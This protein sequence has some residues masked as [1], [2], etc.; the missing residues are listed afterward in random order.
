[1]ARESIARFIDAA[2]TNMALA[3]KVAAL[4]AEHGYNFVAEELLE[5]GA[6]RPLSDADAEKAAAGSHTLTLDPHG[7]GKIQPQGFQAKDK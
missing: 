2:M 4:A 7:S 3:A 1:M 5:L 6:V